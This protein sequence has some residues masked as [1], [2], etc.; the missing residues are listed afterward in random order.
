MTDRLRLYNRALRFC[1]ERSLASL[2]E[3]VPARHYLDE[4]WNDGFV[5]KV[6]EA[7]LWN[8]AI[9]TQQLDYTGA[10][11]PSYGYRRA[12]EKPADWVRTAGLASD[13]YL[14]APLN[15]YVDE[16]GYW[17]ADIDQLYVRFVSS[18][19]AYGADLG[20]WPE[21]VHEYAAC[22]LAVE[23]N[24]RLTNGRTDTQDLKDER[25]RLLSDAK[26]KDGMNQ[27]TAS[28]PE[29]SWNRA[30]HGRWAGRDGGS[31]SSLTG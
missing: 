24:P 12:F 29:G 30:R 17:Y 27:A 25:K 23:I 9:R 21:S 15:A 6:L 18:D 28:R 3:D 4:A 19:D 8:F 2:S 7:G 20:Q 1:G 13:E 31:R 26:T 10:V 14:N 11:T 22:R 5:R 16:G